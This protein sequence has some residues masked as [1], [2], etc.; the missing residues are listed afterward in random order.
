MKWSI[1]AHNMFHRCQRQYLFNNIMASETSNEELWR[2][3]FILKQLQGW[4][5]WQE[6]LVHEG[7]RLFVVPQLRRNANISTAEIIGSTQALARQ[8]FVFSQGKSYRN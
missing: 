2:E 8:Q 7:I 5:A 1:S 6:S 4:S 3:A